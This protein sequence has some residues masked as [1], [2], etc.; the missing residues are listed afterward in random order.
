M[1]AIFLTTFEFDYAEEYLEEKVVHEE[2][3]I[4]KENFQ[5]KSV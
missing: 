3:H 5:E 2:E 1:A 4:E